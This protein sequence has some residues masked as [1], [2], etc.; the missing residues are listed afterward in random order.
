[1]EGIPHSVLRILRFGEI[2][3]PPFEEDYLRITEPA[4]QQ[5]LQTVTLM[6]EL[7]NFPN[8]TLRVH[9]ADIGAYDSDQ[10][11]PN[12]RRK[13]LKKQGTAIV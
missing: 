11:L 2:V 9:M 12:F 6:K 4:Y 8:F 3:F 7:L 5:W 13:V 1:M 10:R